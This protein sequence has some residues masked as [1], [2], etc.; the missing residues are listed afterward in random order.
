MKPDSK[1][2]KERDMVITQG[3]TEL[4]DTMNQQQAVLEAAADS[5]CS[6]GSDRPDPLAL[7]T[8][9]LALAKT[10]GG[11]IDSKQRKDKRA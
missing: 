6:T 4:Q 9:A 5:L 2:R 8:V 7:V 10:A 1:Q 3:I 11:I